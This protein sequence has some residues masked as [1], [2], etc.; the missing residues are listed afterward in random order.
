MTKKE[1]LFYQLS[2]LLDEIDAIFISSGYDISE[3]DEN[4]LEEDGDEVLQS[5]RHICRFKEEIEI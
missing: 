3:Y 4:E 5:Y 2:E 1:E